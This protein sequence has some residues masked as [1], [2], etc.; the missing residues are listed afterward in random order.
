VA[1]SQSLTF[2]CCL[3]RLAHL[4]LFVGTR[5]IAFVS[6]YYNASLRLGMFEFRMSAATHLMPPSLLQIPSKRQSPMH[7]HWVPAS[8]LRVWCD[9]ASAHLQDPYVWRFSKDG[10]EVRKKS[11]KNLFRESDMYTFV[12]KDGRPNQRICD[13]EVCRPSQPCLSPPCN[14]LI[15]VYRRESV[16]S[17]TRASVPES[18]YFRR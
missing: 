18:L 15:R 4:L 14:C 6:I 10:S 5:V 9:P 12:G 17:V 11:P 3:Y 13:L 8:Y 1:A 16:P 7:Q 2:L